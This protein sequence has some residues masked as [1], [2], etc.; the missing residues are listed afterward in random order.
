M[1]TLFKRVLLT[2]LLC[3]TT[4]A[5]QAQ[6]QEAI[7]LALNIEKLNQLRQILQNMYKAYTI[8]SGGYNKVKD[9]TSGNYKIHEAFMD[10]LMTVNP[11][12]KNY[13]RVADIIHAQ[14]QLLKEYKAAY[15]RFSNSGMMCPEE[16]EYLMD[17][18]GNLVEQSR[19]NLDE[20]TMFLTSGNFKMTDDER[21][22]G[23]D[24]IYDQMQDK[25]IFLRSFNNK[26]SVL[27]LQ[28]SKQHK[29][30]QMFRQLYNLKPQ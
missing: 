8:I 29:D 27:V 23:I 10:G 24:R 30:V 13:R 16:L 4:V 12:I 22:A 1:K 25:L 21:L 11:K 9:I 7:Q 28:R 6:V 15:S 2:L 19:Q 14:G 26:T 5:S 18:Y 3:S 20:L 17:V